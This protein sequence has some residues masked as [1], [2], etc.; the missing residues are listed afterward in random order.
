MIDTQ[1]VKIKLGDSDPVDLMRLALVDLML[2]L[3]K[4]QHIRV[5]LGQTELLW[6]QSLFRPLESLNWPR[7]DGSR[8]YRVIVDRGGGRIAADLLRIIP[9]PAGKNWGYSYK[10]RDGTVVQLPYFGPACYQIVL[11]N[12]ATLRIDPKTNLTEFPWPP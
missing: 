7:K 9:P 8:A 6:K 10:K 1:A 4:R 12:L 3:A 11:S 2:A 5:D